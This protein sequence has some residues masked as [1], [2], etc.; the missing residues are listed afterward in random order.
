MSVKF[1]KY[2]N[3][4]NL[5]K[6]MIKDGK[7]DCYSDCMDNLSGVYICSDTKDFWVARINKDLNDEYDEEEVVYLIERN[8]I[9]NWDVIEKVGETFNKETP[10]QYTKIDMHNFINETSERML[11][12][13]VLMIDD[14]NGLENWDNY[15][16]DSLEDAIDN[17]AD[18]YGIEEF[19]VAM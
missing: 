17:L 13:A 6:K 14:F 1:A 8:K 7:L 15:Q 11:F 18:I 5:V 12:E 19:K 10:R 3:V 9:D 2:Y 16:C 4:T